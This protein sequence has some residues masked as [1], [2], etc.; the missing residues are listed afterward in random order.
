[1]TNKLNGIG[2][3]LPTPITST[4]PLYCPGETSLIYTSLRYSNKSPVPWSINRHQRPIITFPRAQQ[5]RT[6][7][8]SQAC[9]H[10]HRVSRDNSTCPISV[11]LFASAQTVHG[12]EDTVLTNKATKVTSHGHHLDTVTIVLD[13]FLSTAL[14]QAHRW[15]MRSHSA[16]PKFSHR[17]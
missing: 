13:V 1:M 8:W 3:T 14:R 9:Q 16:M 2:E 5:K 7:S 6:N 17:A 10:G 11:P 15:R 4:V 12:H